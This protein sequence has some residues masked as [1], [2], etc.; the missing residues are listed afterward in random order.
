M[1]LDNGDHA[2]RPGMYA[3]ATIV[4]KPIADA[5][6][7][8]REAIIDTGTRQIAFV[9]KSEGHFD[10]RQVRMGMSGDGDV[11]EI[12]EGLTPGE[13]VVT[14]GQFLMDVESRTTEAINKLRGAQG[15]QTAGSSA[16][17]PTTQPA[18]G[19]QPLV[20]AHCPMKNADWV[21]TG[22]TIANPYYGSSMLDCGEVTK[23]VPAPAA[24][25]DLRKF[26]QAYLD[27]TK[28]LTTD[29]FNV[30]AARALKVSAQA[31]SGDEYKPLRQSADR[32]AAAKDINQARTELATVSNELI[33][34]LERS[35]R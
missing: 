7:V 3:T 30:E 34:A 33:R 9:A 12:L 16:T 24:R 8:P 2:L 27:L 22:E 21:Q 6:L 10:P 32:L 31:L 35:G 26:M 5:V 20:V 15:Q 17:A 29:Q 19:A 11:V 13:T 4:T 1:T 14:S 28:S 25:S 18:G 23:K